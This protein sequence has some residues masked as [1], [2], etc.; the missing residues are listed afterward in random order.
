MTTMPRRQG[1]TRL[2]ITISAAH[3]FKS[4]FFL[5]KKPKPVILEQLK[6]ERS[7]NFSSPKNPEPDPIPTRA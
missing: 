3:D 7:S 2:F 4:S 1:N 5:A 6:P